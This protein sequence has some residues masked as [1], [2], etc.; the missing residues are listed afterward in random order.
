VTA[1]AGKSALA[2][3]RLGRGIVRA[4]RAEIGGAL[5]RRDE[6]SGFQRLIVEERQLGPDPIGIMIFLDTRG[7]DMGDDARSELIIAISADVR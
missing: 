4:A 1:D 6:G 7:N 3:G 2:F 5:H